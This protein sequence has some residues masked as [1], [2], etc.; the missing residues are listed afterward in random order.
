MKLSSDH[1]ITLRVRTNL[2]MDTQAV[3]A[4]VVAAASATDRKVAKALAAPL[5]VAEESL[6][7]FHSLE[8]LQETQS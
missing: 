4:A 1:I 7:T 3:A 8:S 2:L 5:G 6:R